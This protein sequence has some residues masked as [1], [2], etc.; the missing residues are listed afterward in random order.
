MKGAEPKGRRDGQLAHGEDGLRRE[1][2]NVRIVSDV[3]DPEPRE[4]VPHG[5]LIEKSTD[6]LEVPGADRLN[7]N[8]NAVGI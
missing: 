7:A 2:V 3:E 6:V 1:T 8:A 5:V 4:R